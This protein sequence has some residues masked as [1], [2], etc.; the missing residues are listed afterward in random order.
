MSHMALVFTLIFVLSLLVV[1]GILYY[2]WKRAMRGEI[3][4]KNLRAY[5]GDLE[6]AITLRDIGILLLYVIKHIIQFF[7]VQGLKGYYIISKKIK[8]FTHHRNSP[9]L[10]KAIKKLKLPPIPPQVKSFVYKTVNETKQKITRVK[11]DLA[12]LEET[13]DKRVD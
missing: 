5:E 2:Q 6:P 13:I 8:D 4:I 1:I 12:E 11:Q 10:A 7:I 9:K 3:E